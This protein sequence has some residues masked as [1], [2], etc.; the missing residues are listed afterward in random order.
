MKSATCLLVASILASSV[1]AAEA[2]A[3]DDI[4]QLTG[5]VRV[6]FEQ[7]CN[8]CHGEHLLKP[9]GKFG[10]VL[11]LQSLAENPDYI[12]P[13]DPANSELFRL[14]KHAEMPPDDQ[15]KFAKL[16]PSEIDTVRRWILAG[17]PSKLPAVL[18]RP[19]VTSNFAS[20]LNADAIAAR[21]RA[22]QKLITIE[23]RQR[24][25][26]EILAEI[27]ERSGITIEY[28]KPAREPLA[29][30]KLKDGTVFDALQYL[31]LRGN[32]AL[33]FSSG[34]PRLGPNPPPDLP[35]EIGPLRYEA[36][37][38]PGKAVR[39]PP[40]PPAHVVTP[41]PPAPVKP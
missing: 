24:P 2:P 18:P 31:A 8:E 14:L 37:A 21:E 39:P 34:N 41:R 33:T 28:E 10:Y 30:I 11:D 17:A 4:L 1:L 22:R 19:P 9:E 13:G 15:T 3:T 40:S 6:L 7:R 12:E 32:F 29:T 35:H 26:G 16:N 27:R 36:L 25:T 23:A 20:V 38:V 5:R